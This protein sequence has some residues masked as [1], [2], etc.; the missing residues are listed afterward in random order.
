MNKL[1]AIVTFFIATISQVN[2]QIYMCKGKG[3][4]DFFSEAA[5]EDIKAVN[6]KVTA[7]LQTNSGEIQF[8]VIIK[9]FEFEKDLMYKHFL[10]K[11]YMWAEKYAASE[12]VGK[13]LNVSE[14]DFKK[15]GVYEVVVE[16]DLTIRGVS[17]KYKIPGTITVN[18][19]GSFVAKAVF[20][21][22]LADH[23]VPIPS[24]VIDNIAEVVAVS[25]DIPF[26]KYVKQ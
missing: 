7:L 11:K 10:E 1:I 25:I 3:K 21:V 19:D 15:E 18:A 23:E 2:A 16:G 14:I 8:K 22:A 17:K 20:D 12:F 5:L 24:V 26:V 13:V 6:N 4:V 9:A